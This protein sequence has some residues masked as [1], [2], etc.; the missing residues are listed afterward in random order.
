MKIIK[1][2]RYGLQGA[3]AAVVICAGFF[4]MPVASGAGVPDKGETFKADARGFGNVEV[5]LRRLGE[6][7]DASW[8]T[9]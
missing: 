7:K 1:L 5:T 8:T 4:N 2:K 3:L 9:F 6:K